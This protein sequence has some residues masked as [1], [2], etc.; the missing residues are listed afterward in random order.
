MTAFY[1]SCAAGKLATAQLLDQAGADTTIVARNG[2]RALSAA[3]TVGSPG[4]REVVS[5]GRLTKP[6]ALRARP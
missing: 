5:R 1:L 2:V 6:S 4:H 3:A